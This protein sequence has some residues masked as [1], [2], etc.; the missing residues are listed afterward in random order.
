MQFLWKYIGDLVGK[1]LEWY[2]ILEF[3]FYSSIHLIPLALPLAILLSSIMTMGNLGERY[4]LAAIKSSGVSLLKAMRPMMLLMLFMA[5]LT[6][7]TTNI[8]I[9]KANLS[10]GALLYDVGNKKPAM[11]IQDG[12]FYKELDGYAIRVGYKHPDNQTVEDI[13]IYEDGRNRTTKTILLAK[14]GKMIFTE[15]QRYLI[16]KL[17]KGVRYEEMIDNPSYNRSFPHN[18]MYFDKQEIAI[19]LEELQFKR[20]RKELFKD[21][22]RMLN[23]VELKDKSDSL[24]RQIS[25]KY[26]YLKQYLTPYFHFPK[27]STKN[28]QFSTEQLE[29]DYIDLVGNFVK[30]K[31]RTKKVEVLEEEVIRDTTINALTVEENKPIEPSPMEIEKMDQEEMKKDALSAAANSARNI[32]RVINSSNKEIKFINELKLKYDVEWH[33]KFTLAISCIILFFIG[34]PLGAIIRK[35]GFGLPLVISI[36][37]FIVYYIINVVGEKLAKEGHLHILVGM[38]MSSAL[39]FPLAVFLTYKASTDS[40]L[41]DGESWRRIFRIFRKREL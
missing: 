8:L 7:Y 5:L 20:T 41:L 18:T 9:P 2:I 17:E 33:K 15:D 24:N 28:Y 19:N 27:D 10:W 36:L 14:K 40:R 13:T 35:G 29:K 37:L 6:F 34:A 11:N 31:K 23:I 25:N 1:G 22:Y 38:W 26:S 3:I 30:L 16:L 32:Q 39:L 12:I 21:D 4:E